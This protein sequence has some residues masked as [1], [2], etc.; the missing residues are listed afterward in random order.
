MYNV[1]VQVNEVR[2]PPHQEMVTAHGGNLCWR[3]QASLIQTLANMY[4]YW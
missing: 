1:A 4:M 2:N 3:Y